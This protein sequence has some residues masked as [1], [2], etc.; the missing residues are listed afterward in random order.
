MTCENIDNAAMDLEESGL[1]SLPL[2]GAIL[3][4]ILGALNSF[5]DCTM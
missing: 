5:F 4:A 2:I 3:T 1:L